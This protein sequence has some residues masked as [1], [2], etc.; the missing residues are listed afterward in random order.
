MTKELNFMLTFIRGIERK[1]LERLKPAGFN[2]I[3]I[4]GNLKNCPTANEGE[5]QKKTARLFLND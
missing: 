2:A 4:G 5:N 1:S 3:L